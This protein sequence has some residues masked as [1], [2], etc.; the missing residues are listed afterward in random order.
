MNTK[1]SVLTL[2]LF[3]LKFSIDARSL[4]EDLYK[5]YAQMGGLNR[6]WL[7]LFKTLPVGIIVSQPKSDK[8]GK[9][10]PTSTK[11]QSDKK[12]DNG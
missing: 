5:G 1:L 4:K 6:Q 2:A 3:A 7:G 9:N 10:D 8:N 12:T 11:I